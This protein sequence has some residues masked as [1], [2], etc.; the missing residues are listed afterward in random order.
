MKIEAQWKNTILDMYEKQKLI[1]FVSFRFVF[2]FCFV[3]HLEL[4]WLG[5][6]FRFVVFWF[7]G[8]KTIYTDGEKYGDWLCGAYIYSNNA[9]QIKSAAT[10]TTAIAIAK[11]NHFHCQAQWKR[12]CS[13][14]NSNSCC[15]HSSSNPIQSNRIESNAIHTRLTM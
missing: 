7:T 13:S 11:S 12:N 2:V 3:F 15:H 5:W 8:H 1:N 4:V 9:R 6:A 14:H 10:T